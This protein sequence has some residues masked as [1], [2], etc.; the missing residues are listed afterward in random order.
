M[1]TGTIV[2]DIC[3]YMYNITNLMMVTFRPVY[4]AVVFTGQIS[5]ISGQKAFRYFKNNIHFFAQTD[6]DVLHKDNY[7]NTPG[8]ITIPL[9]V[10]K[11]RQDCMGL[12]L[13]V[14]RRY[15]QKPI[16]CENQ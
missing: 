13:E 7:D 12:R 10:F 15:S 11:E 9:P 4:Y 16:Y 2:L 14:L 1:L 5:G 6:G 3:T 8:S